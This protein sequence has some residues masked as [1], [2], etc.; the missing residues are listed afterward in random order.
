[1]ERHYKLTL[2]HDGQTYDHS[3]GMS[4]A[5]PME[6]LAYQILLRMDMQNALDNLLLMLYRTESHKTDG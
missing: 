4:L 3:V 6:P 1:M 2:E 5:K